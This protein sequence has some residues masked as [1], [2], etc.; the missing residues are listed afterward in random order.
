MWNSKVRLR[1]VE[2]SRNWKK[3]NAGRISHLWSSVEKNP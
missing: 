1:K 3:S 2:I